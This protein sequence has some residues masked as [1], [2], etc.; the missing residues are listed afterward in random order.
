[1][2]IYVIKRHILPLFFLIIIFVT[3]KH[4]AGHPAENWCRLLKTAPRQNDAPD[5]ARKTA[6]GELEEHNKEHSV[7]AA[8]TPS[9]I[10]IRE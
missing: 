1:M 9:K 6:Q 5:H 7:D 3:I 8:S 10:F 4:L 2:K